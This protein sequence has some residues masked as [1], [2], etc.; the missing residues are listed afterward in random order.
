MF[1]PTNLARVRRFPRPEQISRYWHLGGVQRLNRFVLEF[2]NDPQDT[3][4]NIEGVDAVGDPVIAR[5]WAEAG[6][7]RELPHPV[8]RAGC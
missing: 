5:L 1:Q 7:E 6:Y 8:T 3:S 2:V 4:A